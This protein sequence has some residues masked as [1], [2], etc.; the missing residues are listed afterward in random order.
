MFCLENSFYLSFLFL[1]IPYTKFF[2]RIVPSSK[3]FAASSIIHLE[4]VAFFDYKLPRSRVGWH[5]HCSQDSSG[6]L[7]QFCPANHPLALRKGRDYGVAKRVKSKT[8]Q[9]RKKKDGR[10]RRNLAYRGNDTNVRLLE[11][12]F[13]NPRRGT[14]A[15][16]DLRRKIHGRSSGSVCVVGCAWTVKME[17]VKGRSKGRDIRMFRRRYRR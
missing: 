8:D 10:E 12:S 7:F 5:V 15:L 3:I 9:Q 17:K 4:I 13:G 11:I 16:P 6:C 14:P 1:A 2:Y